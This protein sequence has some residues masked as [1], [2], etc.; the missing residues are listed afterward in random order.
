VPHIIINPG[1]LSLPGDVRTNTSDAVHGL[2]LQGPMQ[3]G[4]NPTPSVPHALAGPALPLVCEYWESVVRYF[5]FTGLAFPPP[6]SYNQ[7]PR[8]KLGWLTS[9]PGILSGGCFVPPH[10]DSRLLI[11]ADLP[12]SPGHWKGSTPICPH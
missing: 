9:D 1:Q 7:Q 5:L 10:C 6:T 4:D 12:Q 2:S 3:K 8:N 11:G